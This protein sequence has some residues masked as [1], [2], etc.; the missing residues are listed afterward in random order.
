MGGFFGA[1][2][3][4]LEACCHYCYVACDARWCIP[5]RNARARA[6]SYMRKVFMPK[7]RKALAPASTSNSSLN[8]NVGKND[9][10][11]IDKLHLNL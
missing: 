6:R 7:V 10:I 11:R 8:F 1:I 5:V 2:M 4:N 9:R 3:H